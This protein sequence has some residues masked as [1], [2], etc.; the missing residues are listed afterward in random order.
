MSTGWPGWPRLAHACAQATAPGPAV[1]GATEAPFAAFGVF[2]G[3]GGK[4][5]SAHAAKHLLEGVMAAVDRAGPEPARPAPAGSAAPAAGAAGA[6]R[7]G[8]GG[9]RARVAP[10]ARGAAVPDGASARAR[11][12]W[13]LHDELLDRLPKARG[14]A[15]TRVPAEAAR[16]LLVT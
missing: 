5:A 1:A 6:A 4:F 8:G 13:R 3:H 12:L 9:G 16:L 7:G 14:P 15:P 11:A 10:G 2:D